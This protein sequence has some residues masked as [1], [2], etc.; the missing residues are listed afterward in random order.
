MLV[1]NT[2]FA[3]AL[4][5]GLCAGLLAVAGCSSSEVSAEEAKPRKAEVSATPIPLNPQHPDILR[6]GRLTYLGGLQ[7]SSGHWLFGGFSG[8]EISADGSRLLAVSDRGTWWTADL[9]LKEGVPVGVANSVLTTM[10]DAEGNALE[11]G[12]NDAEG[13]A[14]GSDGDVYVSF[15]RHHRIARFRPEDPADPS[16]AVLARETPV[17]VPAAL[18]DAPSNGG[19]EALAALS[20][21]RL[22][23]L[24]EE[25]PA[26]EGHYRGWLIDGETFAPF[27]FPV[28]PPFKN[29][30][31]AQLPGGDVLVLQRRYGLLSGLGARLCQVPA[32]SLKP[33]SRLVCETV[34]E[35]QPP[36]S[37]DNMEALAVRRTPDG[38]TLV[39]IM[40]D[41]NF[42]ALQR[43]VLLVF[44]LE[45]EEID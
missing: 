38:E 10:A 11:T 23:A 39:Y 5:L 40:S 19:L 37:I 27:D 22:F 20:D 41:D 35:M 25:M 1:T 16:S 15:E 31:A 6:V 7:F 13:L 26:S 42:S 3:N 29:T 18:A 28:H 45:P 43:T 30:D 44:R 17:A 8:L 33:G 21:G 34:A 36:Q 2:T 14:V 12:E 9:V 4:R 24:T 32:S